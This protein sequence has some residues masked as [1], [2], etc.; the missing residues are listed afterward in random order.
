M[1]RRVL[2]CLFFL[3]PCQQKLYFVANGWKLQKETTW[4]RMGIT[5]W[6][7]EKTIR[8]LATQLSRRIILLPDA[9]EIQRMPDSGV[10]WIL[11]D[12]A[13]KSWKYPV[14][15]NMET[16]ILGAPNVYIS[17][18][19]SLGWCGNLSFDLCWNSVYSIY[20]ELSD[21]LVLYDWL[22]LH[23]T[24]TLLGQYGKFLII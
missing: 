18:E 15:Q 10:L 6:C 8:Q 12:D 13:E 24:K 11:S 3:S 23:N 9:I 14:P 20:D 16:V 5:F 2:C 7:L 17:K 21:Q 1:S 22:H 19:A 4:K